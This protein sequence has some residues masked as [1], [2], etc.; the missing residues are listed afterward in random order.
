[1]M[2]K[3]YYLQVKIKQSDYGIIIKKNKFKYFKDTQKMFLQCYFQKM[4]KL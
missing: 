2:E 4:I 3:A 1:M